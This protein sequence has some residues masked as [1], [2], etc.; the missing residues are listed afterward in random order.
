LAIKLA[1]LYETEFL[2]SKKPTAEECDRD[3]NAEL[4]EWK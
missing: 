2:D 4:D 3:E 1:M